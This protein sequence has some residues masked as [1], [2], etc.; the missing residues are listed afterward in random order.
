VAGSSAASLTSALHENADPEFVATVVSLIEEAGEPYSTWFFGGRAQARANL[1]K[2][3]LRP[4][5]EVSA[6][7]VELV[8]ENPG[9]LAGLFIGVPGPELESCRKSDLLVAVASA[10]GAEARNTLAERI[11]QTSDLFLEVEAD[12]YYLSKMAVVRER[13]GRG[14][15]RLILD[16]FRAKGETRGYTRFSLDVAAENTPAVKLYAS[17]GFREQA[18]RERAGMRYLR[19]TFNRL[20]LL[21]YPVVKGLE[22]FPVVG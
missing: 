12:E 1:A 18:A 13:R 9:S 7:R 21:V 8:D 17:A 14:L 4:S 10:H 6:T 11:R 20:T 2:W 15:G 19:M 16:A 5:S 22:W 3:L